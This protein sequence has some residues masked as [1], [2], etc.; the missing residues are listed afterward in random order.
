[1]TQNELKEYL[2]YNEKSGEFAWLKPISRRTKVGDVAGSDSC[3]SILI[4]INKKKYTAHHLAWL[5]KTGK[6]PKYDIKHVNGLK[7]DNRFSN[8]RL[9]TRKR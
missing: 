5:Y 1:M 7:D 8:L 2:S 6:W 3:G 9:G 4:V